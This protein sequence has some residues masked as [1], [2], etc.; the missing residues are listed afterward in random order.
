MK[1][2]LAFYGSA[3]YPEGGM[4]DFLSDY[5]TKE[6]ALRAIS[7]KLNSDKYYYNSNEEKW[8]YAWAHIYDTKEMVKVW[9][10]Q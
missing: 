1:R 5:D 9:S 7:D 8:E 4:D 6:E 2:Y 3:Y 10:K